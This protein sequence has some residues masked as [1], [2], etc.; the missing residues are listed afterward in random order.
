MSGYIRQSV[1][2]IINGANITAPPL[3]AEFNQLA[4]AFNGTTGH[5]HAGGTGEG[6]KIP[7]ATSVSGF[8][9]AVHGGVGGRNNNTAVTDPD[10][11]SDA[12]SG[13]AAGS[14][15]VNVSTGRVFLC[16]ANAANS[17][18]WVEAVGI[19]GGAITPQLTNTVDIGTDT[20]RFKN[21]FLSG[22]LTSA[23]ITTGTASVDT[24]N[25]AVN[26]TFSASPVFNAGITV[27]GASQ[28]NGNATITGNTQLGDATSDTIN[29]VARVSSS[30]VPE[31]TNTRDLGSTTFRFRDL[32]LSG[33]ATI[34]TLAASSA[35]ISGGSING[36]V[37]G[38][39]SPQAITGTTVTAN[40]GFSGN[41]TG[42]VTGNLTGNVTGAVTGNVTG[43][44]TG[45]VTSAGTSTFNNVT[46]SGT[47]DMDAG[48]SST[49]TGLSTPSN[50]TDATTKA[51]VDA[52]D[53]LKLNL[54]GGTM[55]GPI[56]MAGNKITSLGAP[57]DNGDASTKLYVDTAIAD[58]VASSP[59]ALDTLA[60][61]AAALGN[62][63]DFATTVTNE[64][65][66][67]V[68][69]A[70]DT[71]TGNL[72]LS[73]NKVTGLGAPT[74]NEDA[75]R[76]SYVDAADALKLNLTG[77]TMTGAIQMGNNKVSGLG[78]PTAAG[79][80]TTKGYVDA[81]DALKLNLTGGTMSG[82]IAMG[83]NRITDVQDPSNAQDAATKNYID[84]IFGSTQS[85]AD[86]AAAALVSEQNAAASES[87]A[88]LS[89]E[90]FD[91]RYLGEKNT[92][93]TLDNQGDPLITGA[94]YFNSVDNELRVYN[95]AT[96]QAGV[97]D[98][99]LL[100]FRTGDTLTDTTLNNVTVASGTINNTPIG[101]ATPSTG[102]FTTTTA[103]TG[104]ITTVNATTVNATTVDTTNLEVTNLKAKDGTAAGSIAD[105][106]GVVTLASSVLT[107]T[108]I[109]GGTIDGTAI[110]AGTPSTGDFTDFTAS[111]TAEFTST[112]A[113]KLSAGTTAQRPN[114]AK[115]GHIRINIDTDE[116]EGYN[117]TD[118]SSVGGSAISDDVTT[119]TE[120]YPVF[121]DA[122]TGT[123]ANVFVSDGKLGYTPSTGELSA[124]QLVA[125]NGIVV[126][127]ATITANYT[128]PSGSNASSA[129]PITVDDGV[130]V[131]VSANST[132]VIL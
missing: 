25:V 108:D 51:Y 59:E 74:D 130:E 115:P 52:A 103:T 65:A 77:G 54:A 45:D 8:L 10:N 93:P 110:G 63:P 122:T 116:F 41:L 66:T 109:N 38:N 2:D 113:V 127:S 1:A 50:P 102:T 12:N 21:A 95:G 27:N 28:L 72:A 3:N 84:T 20:F 64:I 17:A 29:L 76:K 40:S 5:N 101:G 11:L 61:L 86:S 26:S 100:A 81:Q 58:L 87:A 34:A 89:F 19:L 88:A 56:A 46:I 104:N 121:V 132:W 131:T 83:N 117:G 85:A 53:A 14:I 44:L 39:S 107:T 42:N 112:G 6:P 70:G 98:I 4:A 118:W 75:A 78:T 57:T 15:W 106:T 23:S 69:K 96:W 97:T 94:V 49:I 120:L 7:L 129:G 60:E 37:I 82:V 30:I 13:Y 123:A 31:A 119:A 43:N 67:K 124:S 128:I 9:P 62:D 80:A 18:V 35:T 105:S 111:G 55:S 68:T 114:P 33:T 92:D 32:W 126:N 24:L 71:M 48:T 90:R 16:I 73:G 79:D 47:L 36:T 125:S 22:A 99:S 91:E